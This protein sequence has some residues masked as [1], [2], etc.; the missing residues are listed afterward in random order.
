MNHSHM[1]R[2]RVRRIAGVALAALI[3]AGAVLPASLAW[4]QDQ[5]VEPLPTVFDYVPA[6]LG[7]SA[8]AP[9]A[10]AADAAAEE[11]AAA[12][13]QA[14]TVSP[15][16]LSHAIRMPMAFKDTIPNIADRMGYGTSADRINAYTHIRDL[17]AGWYVDW[18]VN[19][20]PVHP[21]GIEYVQMVRMH[22]KLACPIGTTADRVKCP[23]V[24]DYQLDVDPLNKD[25]AFAKI[26][27]A[28]SENRGSIWLLGNEMDRMDWE[29]TADNPGRQDEMTPQLYA[30]AYHDLYTRIKAA[31]PTA[32]IA[33]GGVIQFTP[34][35]QKY[36][37]IVLSTYHQKYGGSMPID[38]WNIHN[39]V[40]SE[41]CRIEK[42]NNVNT[43]RC[44]GMGIPA[45][46]EVPYNGHNEQR[47]CMN[48]STFYCASYIGEDWR[49]TWLSSSDNK[50]DQYP[51]TEPAFIHQIKEFRS[52]LFQKGYGAKPVIITEYGVLYSSLCQSNESLQNCK[53]RLGSHYVDL[54]NPAVIQDFM[55]GTFEYF[56]TATEPSG[57]SLTDGGHLV[58]R[59]AWFALEPN[60]GFN[61]HGALM[62]PSNGTLTAAG[63][64]YAAF[65]R[66]NWTL[67]QYP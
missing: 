7:L 17:R 9:A 27:H 48:G 53:N 62:D 10:D 55:T 65:T 21:G 28:A 36:L 4:G 2:A 43:R 63:Q 34:L 23:Y 45:G 22:Q 33:I 54:T 3:V 60:W 47:G 61:A 32:R 38:I 50:T 16:A 29:G 59:W 52:W 46:V 30:V 51:F 42:V 40:G 1:A 31:D 57:V 41:Y 24:A 14:V 5:A 13:A 66:N 20:A 58:Q 35:R 15:D 26:Q 12:P 18:K 6:T 8:D 11:G 49:H 67:L 37:E 44:Y 56:T 64:K 39:F 19:D 25:A